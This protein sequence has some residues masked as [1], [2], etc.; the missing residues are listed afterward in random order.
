[1][2]GTDKGHKNK[3]DLTDIGEEDVQMSIPESKQGANPVKDVVEDDVE[4][5]NGKN[6]MSEKLEESVRG[7]STNKEPSEEAKGIDAAKTMS[8]HTLWQDGVALGN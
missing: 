5:S 6:A 4:D 7:K 8:M 2:I 1:M 3:E